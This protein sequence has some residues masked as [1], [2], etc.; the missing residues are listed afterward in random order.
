MWT[1]SSECKKV[2]DEQKRRKLSK[3]QNEDNFK[4]CIHTKKLKYLRTV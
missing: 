2:F 3:T 1:I 4:E